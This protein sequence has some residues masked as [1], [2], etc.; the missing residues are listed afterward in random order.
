MGSLSGQLLLMRVAFGV[1]KLPVPR[2]DEEKFYSTVRRVFGGL[3]A[4]SE[5][6]LWALVETAMEQRH[7][8]ILVISAQA[9]EEQGGST[10]K[11]LESSRQTSPRISFADSAGLTVRFL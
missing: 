7:G 8:T 5:Q 11:P 6:R 4:A 3:A 10:G 2:L 1:P 9:T